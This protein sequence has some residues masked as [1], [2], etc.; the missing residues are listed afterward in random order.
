MT[1][2]RLR[3]IEKMFEEMGLSEAE[4][5]RL[6]AFAGPKPSEAPESTETISTGSTSPEASDA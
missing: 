5:Q 1:P 6:L 4:R 3:E 2:P